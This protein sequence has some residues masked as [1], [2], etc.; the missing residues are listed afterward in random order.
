M[1]KCSICGTAIAENARHGWGETAT[2]I[3]DGRDYVHHR[4]AAGAAAI[5]KAQAKPTPATAPKPSQKPLAEAHSPPSGYL[6]LPQAA[7]LLGLS[8]ATLRRRIKSGS[9]PAFRLGDGQTILIERAALLALLRP[10]AKSADDL[11]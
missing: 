4:C 10:I 7:R 1:K 8:S 2:T 3:N 6:T 5:H 9:L 11:L